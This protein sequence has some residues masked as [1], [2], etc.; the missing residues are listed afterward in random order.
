[1]GRYSI[2]S[3]NPKK[4]LHYLQLN[5][6][7]PKLWDS[8]LSHHGIQ[9]VYEYLSKRL[10]ESDDTR[11]IK[12]RNIEWFMIHCH[13]DDPFLTRTNSDSEQSYI[14]VF[15]GSTTEYHNQFRRQAFQAPPK[16]SLLD[17]V[18]FTTYTITTTGYGD[19]IPVTGYAKFIVSLANLFELFMMVIFFNVLIS[20]S[21]WN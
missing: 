19:I 18:Y 14:E 10:R 13:K 1:M 2:S 17:Y 5:T 16:L 15:I 9:S 7:N 21:K 8:R 12:W 11:D 3:L 20:I 4:A 6:S